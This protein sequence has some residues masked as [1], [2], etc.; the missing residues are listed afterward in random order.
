[1]DLDDFGSSFDDGFD[2]D[3]DD[4]FAAPSRPKRSSGSGKKSKKKRKKKSGSWQKP[5]L[6][7][8]GGILGLALLIGVGY[9]GANLI[10]GFGGG[11]S[12]FSY[13]PADTEIIISVQVAELLESDMVQK[14]LADPQ[15]K[16]ATDKLKQEI[17]MAADED[18]TEIQS[19]IVG[20][21]NMPQ[22]P[23][24]SL[25]GGFGMGPLGGWHARLQQGGHDRRCSQE[26]GVEPRR[27]EIQG[28][29]IDPQLD[30]V[31]R[32]QRGRH[33]GLFP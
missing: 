15:A 29:G 23:A 11:Q 8:G 20:V 4:D 14:A 5:A 28:Q 31:L 18:L 10:S 19:I 27:S 32:S 2:D 33:G 3:F 1:M 24:G 9:L 26:I 16:A 25:G 13:L 22:K 30:N 7:A 12:D 6:I 21:A 17:G